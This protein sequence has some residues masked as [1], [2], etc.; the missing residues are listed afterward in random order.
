[1]ID[2]EVAVLCQRVD[3]GEPVQRPAQIVPCGRCGAAVFSPLALRA[4]LALLH[5]DADVQWL[6]AGCTDDTRTPQ[7]RVALTAGQINEWRQAGMADFEIAM[8]HAFHA[9]Y[10]A[11]EPGTLL[12]TIKRVTAEPESEEALHYFTAL[13]QALERVTAEPVFYVADG[14]ASA[15]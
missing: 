12:E 6:C 9:L 11:A 4:E 10:P 2:D 5:P 14:P 15:N 7:R 1:M 3:D 13:A 8:L